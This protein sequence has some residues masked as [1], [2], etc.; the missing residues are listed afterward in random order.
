M[1]RPQRNAHSLRGDPCEVFPI[2]RGGRRERRLVS[3]VVGEL[4]H[5]RQ[6]VRLAGP[7]GASLAADKGRHRSEEG[8][9]PAYLHPL[10][11][12]PVRRLGHD[13]GK[14]TL[15]DLLLRFTSDCQD[16]I[17]RNEL[18]S[19]MSS[20]RVR[21]A[22]TYISI[23]TCHRRDALIEPRGERVLKARPR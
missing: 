11:E 10:P 2:A 17:T 14:R 19:A 5:A 1:S 8:H 6:Q 15:D 21:E 20:P 7:F 22:S 12:D 9:D 18:R 13:R 23:Q 16:A 3:E 4:T